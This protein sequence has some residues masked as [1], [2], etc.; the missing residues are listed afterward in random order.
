M[1]INGHDEWIP[2]FQD[3]VRGQAPE[4]QWLYRGQPAKYSSL[5]PSQLRGGNRASYANRLRML[6]NRIAERFLDGL[7]IPVHEHAIAGPPGEGEGSAVQLAGEHEDGSSQVTRA[8]LLRGLAQHYG[9]PTMFVDLSL[10]PKVATFFAT[11]ALVDGR[12]QVITDVP[13]IV[14]RWPATRVSETKLMLALERTPRDAYDVLPSHDLTAIYPAFARPRNQFAI[15]TSVAF[16]PYQNSAPT[17]PVGIPILETSIDDLLS[18]DLL[19]V[20]T[21]ERYQLPPSAGQG[22]EEVFRATEDAF[23]PD[24]IDLGNSLVSIVALLSLT[25]FDPEIWGTGTE[26]TFA[27]AMDSGDALLARECYRLLEGLAAPRPRMPLGNV[28]IALR[29]LTEQAR[30]AALLPGGNAAGRRTILPDLNSRYER[31]RDILSVADQ[32]PVYAIEEGSDH[33]ELLDVFECDET[34]RSEVVRQLKAVQSWN[35]SLLENGDGTN[36]VDRP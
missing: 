19:D 7:P 6:D 36:P 33:A 3:W 15:M 35:E 29:E 32:A 14:Y 10:E 16:R 1:A 9:Y 22:V 5:A 26:G 28:S 34:Y 8:E 18:V 23:F 25:A 27:A 30:A 12:Y 24:R 11:H 31:V 13:G 4:F 21:C 20:P 2:G 17:D